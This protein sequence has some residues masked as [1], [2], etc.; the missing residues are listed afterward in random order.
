[1]TTL[2]EVWIE[3]VSG[4]K[5]SKLAI[6]RSFDGYNSLPKEYLFKDAEISKGRLQKYFSNGE[7][8]MN[9]MLQFEGNFDLNSLEMVFS[10][11]GYR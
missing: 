10:P 6:L 3:N 8:F 9:C 4:E 5:T 11:A 2:H 1:M 7:P